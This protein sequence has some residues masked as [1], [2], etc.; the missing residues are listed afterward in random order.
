MSCPVT[1]Q[2]RDFTGGPF[3]V[4]AEDSQRIHEKISPLLREAR[5]VTLSTVG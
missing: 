1:I 3:V 2:I 5:P 4:S